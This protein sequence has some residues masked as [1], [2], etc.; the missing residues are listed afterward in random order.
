MSGFGEEGESRDNMKK[1]EEEEEEERKDLKRNDEEEREYA[2]KTRKVREDS[3]DGE[4][5]KRERLLG[6]DGKQ[7]RLIYRYRCSF[8]DG[9]DADGFADR[10]RKNPC[11]G[12]LSLL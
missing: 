4:G 12:M 9:M 10:E 2:A 8:C 5:E 11:A 1:E 7:R 3:R 6:K